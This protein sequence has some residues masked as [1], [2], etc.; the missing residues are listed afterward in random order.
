[1]S[2]HKQRLRRKRSLPVRGKAGVT[3]GKPVA[4]RSRSGLT[5]PVSGRLGR[6]LAER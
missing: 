5:H 2:K 6:E 1:M 3:R 4:V